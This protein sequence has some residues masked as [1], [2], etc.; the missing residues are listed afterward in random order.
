VGPSEILCNSPGGFSKGVTLFYGVQLD[1]FT[2]YEDYTM[3]NNKNKIEIVSDPEPTKEIEI[4]QEYEPV[5]ADE[6]KIEVR[7]A[8][9]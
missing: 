9:Y 4:V 7:K 6:L 8:E 2:M 5:F 3:F 1:G